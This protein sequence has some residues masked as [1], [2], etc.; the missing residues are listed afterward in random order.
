MRQRFAVDAKTQL[1]G[2][3]G[4]SQGMAV[5]NPIDD[6]TGDVC[7]VQENAVPD[8]MIILPP[9]GR[10]PRGGKAK[11]RLRLRQMPRRDLIAKQ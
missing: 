11:P 3:E 2:D 9:T 7:I 5:R 1:H 10:L 4:R 8:S 6:G